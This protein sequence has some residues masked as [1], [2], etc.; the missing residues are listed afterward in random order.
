LFTTEAVKATPDV[1]VMTSASVGNLEAMWVSPKAAQTN[2]GIGRIPL[3]LPC[4]G[5]I[6]HK[7]FRAWLIPVFERKFNPQ[8]IAPMRLILMLIFRNE[9]TS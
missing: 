5:A 6:R 2:L 9:N 7:T 1:P 8:I 4:F 3:Y